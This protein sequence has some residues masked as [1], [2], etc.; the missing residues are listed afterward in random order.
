[1]ETD[2]LIVGGGPVGV[3]LASLLASQ[4][5]DVRVWERR[6]AEPSASRAIGIHA[7]SLA[8]FAQIG[9]EQSVLAQGVRVREGIATSRGLVLGRLRFD[10]ASDEHPY[11]VTLE[12]WK[13]EAIL[14]TRLAAVAPDALSVGTTFR[15]MSGTADRDAL[16]AHGTI[17]GGEPISIRA[18]F[19]V[20]AD[21]PRSAVRAA[22]GVG[23]RGRTL[24]PQ[25]IM[26][27][28]AD[29]DAQTPGTRAV[30]H[31]DGEGPAAEH[32]PRPAI[33][34]IGPEGLVESFPLPEGR[35]RYVALL[36]NT[37]RSGPAEPPAASAIEPA[38]TLS[39]TAAAELAA[40]VQHR[41]GTRVNA[42]TASMT[43]GF[44]V[45]Q[46]RSARI[47][48]GRAVLIGDAAHEFSPFGGL[49]MNVG[50]LDAAALAPLLS[51]AIREGS[52]GPWPVWAA[53]RSRIA[54]IATL[55]SRA[56]MMLGLRSAPGTQAAREALIRS[57]LA[58][59]TAHTLARMYAMGWV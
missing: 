57:V 52:S 1:M 13:T 32:R 16:L 41:T 47:G 59:P 27:D 8:A 33:I 17:A 42:D 36:R 40:I 7:P 34:D 55:Q 15:G 44:Q 56:N 10:R 38:G 4:G 3:F 28:F 24:A 14:R 39:P 23:W 26:G 30:H 31:A 58:L 35:R 49:G 19:V 51:S 20:G 37:A 50:W 11:V 45:R 43:S 18:R 22:M 21:G 9:A 6:L 46:F 25:Y 48:V 12:Q 53:A 54:R 2:V 5:I 29:P